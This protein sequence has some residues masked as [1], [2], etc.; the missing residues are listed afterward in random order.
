MYSPCRKKNRTKEA[1]RMLRRCTDIDATYVQAHKELFRLHHGIRGAR[2][3][4]RAIKANP[5]NY[6]LKYMYGYWLMD[7]G[8]CD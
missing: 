6:E 4:E 8:N 1:I 7:N 5:Y 2:Y 3:L